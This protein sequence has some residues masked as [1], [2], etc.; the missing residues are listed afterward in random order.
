VTRALTDAMRRTLAVV[1][2]QATVSIVNFA[3]GLVFI[4]RGTP[5]EFALYSAYM[6]AFYFVATAQNALLSTPM[7]VLTSQMPPDDRNSFER[8]L[9]SLLLVSAVP[10]CL[11]VVFA[12]QLATARAG[13][14]ALASLCVGLAL[15][16]LMIRDHLRAQEFAN[17]RPEVALRRDV[18]FAIIALAGIALSVARIGVT[19]VGTVVM[20]GL[21]CLIVVGSALNQWRASAGR[22]VQMRFAW[23][24]SWRHSL[25]SFGGAMAAWFQSYAYVFVPLHF[26]LVADVAGMS[27]ARIVI[28]PVLLATQSWGNLFRP[29]ASRLVAARDDAGLRRMF[30][31]STVALGSIVVGYT[32]VVSL[33]LPA[34]PERLLPASYRGIAP[35]VLLWGVIVLVQVLRGNISNVLQAALAFRRLTVFGIVAAATTVIVSVIAVPIYGA[36][37]ALGSL[38]AG[39]LVL[40]F[41][42]SFELYQRMARATLVVT[43]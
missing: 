34:L 10:A 14:S 9:F 28:M 24:Q 36:A 39:E 18:V 5:L 6:S 1:A 22:R 26:G 2:D 19:A 21:A 29:T 13:M 3:I 30:W 40:F 41:S 8:G 38:A 33:L 43:G 17:L 25:W 7:M 31:R 32:L 23:R 20:L 37:G 35:I 16:P 11:L 12:L 42:L 27:A 4:Y 15:V